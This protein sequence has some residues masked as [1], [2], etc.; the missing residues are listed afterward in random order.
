MQ[1]TDRRNAGARWAAR[2]VTGGRRRVEGRSVFGVHLIDSVLR[3]V[4]GYTES[5]N[6]LWLILAAVT[7][8]S[9]VAQQP[10]TISQ[11]MWDAADRQIVRLKPTAF[12]EL[13]PNII[14]A[15]Q[16]RGC[17]IPQVPMIDG[18]Q[19]VIKGEFAK[20]GQ[21]DWAVLCSVGRVSSILVFWNA[22]ETTP[23][24]IAT[25]KDID[26]LQGWAGDKIV[27]S[28]AITPVGK[29]YILEHYKAYGGEKP[30]PIDHQGINDIDF[31][32]ASEVLYF[33]RGKWLHLTGAD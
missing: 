9:C 23:T 2:C 6:R 24:E 33:Y 28:S 15:L 20:P 22:S 21:A 26:R 7:V 3:A 17:T 5:M 10:L 14:A 11:S 4:C 29:E 30:P 13:P 32:K 8:G 31:G 19:N 12:P 1:D 16:R 18:R 25:R 27:Y